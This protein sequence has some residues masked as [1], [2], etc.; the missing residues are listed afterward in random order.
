MRKIL[1]SLV[2][3]GAMVGLTG[4][5]QPAAYAQKKKETTTE[6]DTK[7]AKKGTKAATTGYIEISEGKDGKFRFF[8]RDEDDKLLAMSSPGGFASEKDAQK[9]V[10]ELKEVIAKAKVT[11]GKKKAKD[12]DADK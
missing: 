7:E 11:K 12:K 4:T 2:L 5:M 10:E 3:M 1:A 8:V 6:K 9:A